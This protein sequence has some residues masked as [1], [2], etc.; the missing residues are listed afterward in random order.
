[1]FESELDQPAF[2]GTQCGDRSAQVIDGAPGLPFHDVIFRAVSAALLVELVPDVIEVFEQAPRSGTDGLSVQV[3]GQ[4]LQ[5][6]VAEL[7][8]D[9]AQGGD[10]SIDAPRLASRLEPRDDLAERKALDIVEA[11]QR[12]FLHGEQTERTQHGVATH[13]PSDVLDHVRARDERQPGR[14][15]GATLIG[16]QPCPPQRLQHIGEYG[17]DVIHVVRVQKPARHRQDQARVAFNEVPP[18]ILVVI[19]NAPNQREV[20]LVAPWGWRRVRR[21]GGSRGAWDERD[22]HLGRQGIRGFPV[23]TQ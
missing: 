17:P 21:G 20:S 12:A 18:R 9:M 19:E 5:P 2:L 22:G 16:P 1:M 10:E 6:S 14:E 4:A 15:R 3:V 8:F 23:R 7:A 13:A 11:K